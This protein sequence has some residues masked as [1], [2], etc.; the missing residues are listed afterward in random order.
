MPNISFGHLFYTR[1]ARRESF[2]ICP[3]VRKCADGHT[4]DNFFVKPQ[5]LSKWITSTHTHTKI[6]IRI[7]TRAIIH[8]SSHH[9][10]IGLESG[11]SFII[12]LLFGFYAQPLSCDCMTTSFPDRLAFSLDD[13]NEDKST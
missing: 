5:A 11:S 13:L 7:P 1:T 4:R 8:H 10:Q 2:V 12:V 9:I 6:L 3:F